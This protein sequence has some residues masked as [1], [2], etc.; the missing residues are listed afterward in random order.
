M[1]VQHS[2]KKNTPQVVKKMIHGDVQV[3][4]KVVKLIKK[5]EFVKIF[6]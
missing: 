1:K 6:K 5:C 4:S 3:C 2:V